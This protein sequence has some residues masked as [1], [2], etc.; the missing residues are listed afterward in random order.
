MDNATLKDILGIEEVDFEVL[1]EAYNKLP[2]PLKHYRSD[3]GIVIEIPILDLKCMPILSDT[4]SPPETMTFQIFRF[5]LECDKGMPYWRP[6]KKV[7]MR[8]N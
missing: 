8:T 4:I 5:I 3:R 2:D 7:Y 6:M 1:A